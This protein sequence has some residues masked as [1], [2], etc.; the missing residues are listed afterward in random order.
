MQAKDAIK[1]RVKDV[2]GV[3][4][5]RCPYDFFFEAI[6]FCDEL[7]LTLELCESC[8]QQEIKLGEKK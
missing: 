3:V 1:G 5:H 7:E 4:K 6:D 8:W 2:D